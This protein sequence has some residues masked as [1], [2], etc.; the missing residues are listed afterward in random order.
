[1]VAVHDGE[2]RALPPGRPGRLFVS[3]EM[4]FE[5][6]TGGGDRRED[7]VATGDLGHLD[8]A[9]RVYVDG[10]E[11]DMIVSGGENVFPS[12]VENLL[13]D[14]PQVREVA[15]IGVPDPGYGQV[16][17]AFVVRHEGADLD[18][19]AVREHVRRRLARFC[20]PKDVVF[21]PALPRN[22]TGKVVTRELRP[23]A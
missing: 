7:A 16:L 4:L 21:L 13:A 17:A 1:V 19:E 11:D 3:N 22:A 8:A 18:G 23:P 20:V 10:R 15:V 5:G 2:G 14:L 6:Y 9:G 12:Q